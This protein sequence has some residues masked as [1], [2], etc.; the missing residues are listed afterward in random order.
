MKDYHSP[1]PR[2]IEKGFTDILNNG[3][4]FTVEICLFKSGKEVFH[5]EA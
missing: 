5:R 2:Y 4:M 1:I 3:E